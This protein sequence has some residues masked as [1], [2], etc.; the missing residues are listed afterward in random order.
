MI[1]HTF[2]ILAQNSLILRVILIIIINFYTLLH[3][4]IPLTLT[5]IL[6]ANNK[7]INKNIT[8]REEFSALEKSGDLLESGEYE[9][10]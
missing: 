4:L 8:F 2:N 3:L 5:W 7:L 10:I 6:R 1:H 9:G